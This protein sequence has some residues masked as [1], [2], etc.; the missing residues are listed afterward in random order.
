[1]VDENEANKVKAEIEEMLTHIRVERDSYLFNNLHRFVSVL[2]T[3]EWMT[4][5]EQ[6]YLLDMGKRN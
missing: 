1:M 2:G 5:L 4:H 3:P 6:T